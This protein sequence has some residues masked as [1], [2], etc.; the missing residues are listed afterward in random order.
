MDLA[1][2][3]RVCLKVDI[4]FAE[5]VHHGVTSRNVPKGTLSIPEAF[6]KRYL[7]AAAVK[8]HI[9]EMQIIRTNVVRT[10]TIAQL[11]TQSTIKEDRINEDATMRVMMSL[12]SDSKMKS[13][14]NLNGNTHIIETLNLATVMRPTPK[15]S[16]TMKFA[17]KVL[18]ASRFNV[19]PNHAGRLKK[20]AESNGKTGNPGNHFSTVYI[21]IVR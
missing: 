3:R 11:T 15:G 1:E 20:R 21:S 14:L 19:N 18:I 4:E 9:I 6:L 13:H 16:R 8:I 2:S 10:G 17:S 12:P 5:I 7:A